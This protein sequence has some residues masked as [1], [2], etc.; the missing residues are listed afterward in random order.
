MARK[1]K[2]SATMLEGGGPLQPA[3]A[4]ILYNRRTGVIF[5]TH[6]FSATS[7]AKLPDKEELDVELQQVVPGKAESADGDPTFD[8]AM[9][10]M[11]V[12]AVDPEGQLLSTLL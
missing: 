4:V 3:T 9:R 6:Y 10:S 7:D 12:V 5:S 8:A 11:P 2:S 1:S